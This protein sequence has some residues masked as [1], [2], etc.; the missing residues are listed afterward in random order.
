MNPTSA[1][2]WGRVP[3]RNK[4]SPPSGSH[5]PAAAHGFPSPAR[6]S[7]S[8]RRSWC[9]T[10]ARN[11]FRLLHPVPQRL[12]VDAQPLADPPDRPTRVPVLFP[13][14]KH[15]LHR[16]FPQLRR[17]RLP[18]CHE[19]HPSLRSHPPRKPGRSIPRHARPAAPASAAAWH[20]RPSRPAA[21]TSCGPPARPAARRYRRTP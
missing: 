9:R 7:A 13:Q 21:S 1:A 20:A 18:R 10:A 14:V 5:S 16:S 12:R 17:V 8:Y 3:G 2:V 6:R 4:H 15:H 11:R 19:K